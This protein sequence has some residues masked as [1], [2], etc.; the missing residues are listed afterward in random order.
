MIGKGLNDYD[1]IFEILSKQNFNGWISV[2]DGV[3]GMQE[4]IESVEFLKEIRTK[5]FG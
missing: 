4:M 3:N 1:T 2:E 5:Y